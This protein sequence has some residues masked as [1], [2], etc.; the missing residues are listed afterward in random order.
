MCLSLH[1]F[2]KVTLLAILVD[3]KSKDT[4]MK[5][6]F[7]FHLGKTVYVKEKVLV[8]IFNR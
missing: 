5:L 8:Y 7:I 6:I 1:L 3:R 2:C 4:L